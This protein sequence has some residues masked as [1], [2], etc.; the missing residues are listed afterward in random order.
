MNKNMN[1]KPLFDRRGKSGTYAVVMALILLAVLVVV[2]MIVGS[3]PSKITMLDTS[4]TGKYDISGTSQSF[5]AGVKEKVTIYHICTDGYEDSEFE[6]FIDRYAS[7]NSNISVSKIDPA[8]NP[9]FLEKYQ[10]T[11]LNENSIIVESDKRTKVI[12]YYDFFLFYC[13]DIDYSMTYDEYASYGYMYES[14]YGYSFTPIQYFDS[15]LTLGIEYV[16]AESVP[17]VYLLNGHGEAEF[18]D[19][20]K[21]NLDYTG[22]TYESINLALGD[23]IPD[24]STCLIIHNPTSDLTALEAATISNYLENGGNLLLITSNGADKFENLSSITEK[25]GLSAEAGS[26]YEG[27]SNSH[28]PNVPGYIYPTPNADHNATSYISN[29]GIK[30]LFAGAHGIKISDVSGI[31]STALYTTSDKAYSVVDGANGT[32]EVKNLGVIAESSDGG[33][34]CW[35][36]SGSLISDALISNTNG[37]NF[38]AF[39]LVTGWLTGSYS[40]SLA[41]IPGIELSEPTITTTATDANVWGT[42]LIFIIPGAVLGGGIGYWIYRRRR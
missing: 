40:S 34:L 17:S 33:K 6:T 10:A 30:V 20:V 21:Q 41:D 5:I 26:V 24:D 3:L 13:A 23:E 19:V 38:Y 4:G 2:N 7:M 35:I 42:I 36:A 28:Y 14:Y 22:M 39:Y 32:A 15:V 16:C 9:D 11:D 31:T 1:K 18:A 27:D 12:D 25:W 37:G 29:N 8:R